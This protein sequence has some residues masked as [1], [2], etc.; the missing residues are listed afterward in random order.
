MI[1]ILDFGSQYTQL[2]ARRVR[3]EHIYCKILPYNISAQELKQFKGIILSG[4]PASVYDKDAPLGKPKI[5]QL[6][7]PVLGICYGMQW[8]VQCLGGE[9]KSAKSREYGKAKLQIMSSSALFTELPASSQVWMSHGDKVEHLP[10]GFKVIGETANSPACAIANEERNIYGL[11]FH[12]EV[13]HTTYG[14]QIIKNF[15]F[16]ICQLAPTWTMESFIDH[17]IKE[18]KEKVENKK[19]ICAL[20]GGVDSS[21]VAVLLHKAIGNQLTCIFVNNGLLRKYEAQRVIKTF[22]DYYHV[23]LDYCDA[24]ERFLTKLKDVTNPE[25]KRKIIG[26]EFIKVFEEEAK[27]IGDVDFLAQGTLYPDVIESVSTKGPSATIKTHHNVGGLP[28]KMHLKLIEPFRELFKD[29]VRILAKELGLPDE[30][31]WQHPFPGPGLAVRIIGEITME[32]LNILREADWII[33][34]EIKKANLYHKLWQCFAVFLPVKTVGV[35]GDERTYEDVIAVRAVT[36][37][38]AMTAD[39]A[40]LPH[41]LLNKIA[42]K[43]VNE[44][45]G[46][47]RVV[48]DITS[49]PPGTIE[50]E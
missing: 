7:L 39:W 43:I 6:R 19:I 37:Q 30:I 16:K 15:L 31:V 42:T 38:D 12:P 23:N 47:N 50:W 4:G 24:S 13:V 49:K 3:E 21:T 29:E 25:L 11:Q 18:I 14:M 34:Q 48:Y 46:I 17:E 28:E 8:L 1:A 35:M 33:E 44:V 40:Q 36:S 27:K 26:N 10:E 9:V 41:S 45:K 5:L 20:S 22:R 2:I 32:R